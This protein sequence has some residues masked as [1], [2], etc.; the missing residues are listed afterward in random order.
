LPVKAHF[1]FQ[2]IGG[3]LLFAAAKVLLFCIPAKEVADFLIF[4]TV[5][6]RPSTAESPLFH[7]NI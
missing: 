4:L 5:R 6:E 2:A 1:C 7:L 3:L